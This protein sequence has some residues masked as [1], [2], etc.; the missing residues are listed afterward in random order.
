MIK[1][2]AVIRLRVPGGGGGGEALSSE[3]GTATEV[4][5]SVVA[6]PQI[7]ASGI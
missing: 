4:L 1:S 6:D 7:N 5:R 2:K 3:L